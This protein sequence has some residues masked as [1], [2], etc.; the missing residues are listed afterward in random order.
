[1]PPKKNI[2]KTKPKPKAKPKAKSKPKSKPSPT[3]T[4][5]IDNRKI[6]NKPQTQSVNVNV[7]VG[8]K[9]SES[10]TREPRESSSSKK[11]MEQV[12]SFAPTI[13]P[14]YIAGNPPPPPPQPPARVVQSVYTPIRP[15]QNMTS[16][17]SLDSVS[18]LSGTNDATY[19]LRTS[20]GISLDNMSD[21]SDFL[22]REVRSQPS[23]AVSGITTSFTRDPKRN[24]SE[25]EE[26]SYKYSEP[27][28]INLQ[29]INSIESDMTMPMPRTNFTNRPYDTTKLDSFDEMAELVKASVDKSLQ[30][31]IA[32]QRPPL[33]EIVYD[34][35]S[36][37]VLTEEQEPLTLEMSKSDKPA[38]SGISD[39]EF[40]KLSIAERVKVVDEEI[41]KKR[42]KP[43]GTK[44][45]PKEEIKAENAEKLEKKKARE[46]KMKKKME[47]EQRK[48]E[49]R[50]RRAEGYANRQD[51]IDRR[52]EEGNRFDIVE[53]GVT[54]RNQRKLLQKK[55]KE[56]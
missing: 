2:K 37:Q 13:I 53:Q 31:K 1:M 23:Y 27:S 25:L 28:G 7:N 9:S 47:E 8:G 5:I 21:L 15:N 26:E 41:K 12:R 6:S 39:E 4:T 35:G 42:G 3:S 16:L 33:R 55:I 11:S 22:S 10:K 19:G 54:Q 43:P 20:R 17:G 38:L 52:L 30:E 14:Q 45:R 18:S 44:N 56:L 24:W 48:A 49:I 36:I 40:E 51:E 46:E 34:D 32:R 50:E 29:S